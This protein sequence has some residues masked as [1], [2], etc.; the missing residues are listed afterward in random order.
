MREI[1][2]NVTEL[3]GRMQQLQDK[4]KRQEREAQ[5][6]GI[7]ERMLPQQLPLPL[8]DKIKAYCVIPGI[9]PLT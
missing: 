5:Q 2:E 1:N 9:F 6:L 8:W 7:I 3:S 4:L